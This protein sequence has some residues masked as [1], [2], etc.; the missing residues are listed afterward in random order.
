MC[1]CALALRTNALG[2]VIDAFPPFFNISL[3]D[4]TSNVCALSALF[5]F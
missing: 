1:K 2:L 5:R 4:Y 3:G